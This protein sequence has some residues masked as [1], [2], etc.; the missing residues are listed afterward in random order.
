MITYPSTYGV[1]EGA[2]IVHLL[3]HH[4]FSLQLP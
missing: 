4:S 2:C 1:F 3:P